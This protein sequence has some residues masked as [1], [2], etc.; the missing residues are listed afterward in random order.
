MNVWIGMAEKCWSH[1]VS[2]H[3]LKA[4]SSQFPTI[5][6]IIFLCIHVRSRSEFS[7]TQDIFRMIQLAWWPDMQVAELS[8]QKSVWIQG[9]MKR[10]LI[11]DICYPGTE[12]N[13]A[14]NL[15]FAH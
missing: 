6:P 13:V 15:K 11:W 5:H 2:V 4:V 3:F 10:K 7:Y 9:T 14:L 12:S 1:R 8:A